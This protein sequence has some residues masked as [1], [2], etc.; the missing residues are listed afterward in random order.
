MLCVLLQ[1]PCART[2]GPMARVCRPM[3]RNPQCASAQPLVWT[4]H[5]QRGSC[6]A[7]TVLRRARGNSPDVYRHRPSVPQYP[8]GLLQ[9]HRHS[10]GPEA[11]ARLLA[12]H[13]S[14]S[15]HEEVDLRGAGEEKGADK[16]G[17]ASSSRLLGTSLESRFPMSQ[18]VLRAHVLRP[19][20]L[21]PYCVHIGPSL[22]AH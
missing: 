11:Y 19:V 13:R 8:P 22:H 12:A 2:P 1:D 14:I 21:T 3:M 17:A 4:A 20:C 16:R 7:A 5:K 10:P 18:H 15:R 9:C 6:Q